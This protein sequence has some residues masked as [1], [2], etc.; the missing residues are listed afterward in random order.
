M[1]NALYGAE[2][3]G[4]NAEEGVS[5]ISIHTVHTIHTTMKISLLF[6]FF[7]SFFFLLTTLFVCGYENILLP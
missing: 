7:T 5:Y 1:G 6:S 4:T 3:L 2:H